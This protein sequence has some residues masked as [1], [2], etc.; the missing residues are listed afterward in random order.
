[1]WTYAQDTGELLLND[2]IVARGYSG[3]GEGKNNPAFQHV[4]QVGP[5]PRGRWRITG[6]PFFSPATGP[7]CLRLQP[8]PGTDTLGRSGFLFHGDSQKSPGN[9][10]HGCII[11]PRKVREAIWGSGDTE[12][13]VVASLNRKE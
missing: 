13:M 9:A 4:K 10:S 2:L 8:A 5:I 7:Y 1:M 11:V 6:V 12:V 3:H